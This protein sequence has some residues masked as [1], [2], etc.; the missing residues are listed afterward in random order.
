MAARALARAA[1]RLLNAHD[2]AQIDVELMG[3]EYGFSVD[4]LME[5]A[6]LAVAQVCFRQHPPSNGSNVLVCVGPGNNGGDGLVAARH[7][8]H[9]GYSPTVVYPKQPQKELYLSLVK[10]C[11]MLDIPVEAD[12]AAATRGSS[13]DLIVD[14]LFGF[15]F[16]GPPRE[17]FPALLSFIC[18]QVDAGTAV[19]SVDVPSGWDVNGASADSFH[20]ATLVSL[21][22][23]KQ[24]AGH[25]HGNH[26]LGGRFVPPRLAEKYELNLPEY[27]SD[28]G[29]VLLSSKGPSA[30]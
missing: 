5:L 7:L 6:G 27:P 28:A 12:W 8:S 15:G 21:T 18:E 2:S 1:P 25:F 20:P 4:Q 19:L 9:F 17:P 23:P 26:W 13:W 29:V 30:Q 22:S 16:K 3:P 14:S 11:R 24:C 10:Q